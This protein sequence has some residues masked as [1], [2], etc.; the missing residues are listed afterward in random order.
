MSQ[1]NDQD[2]TLRELG[3]GLKKLLCLRLDGC[4]AED[5]VGGTLLGWYE[6]IASRWADEE[7]DAP[8][9]QE[10]FRVL[11]RTC[12]HW[13]APA[14]LVEAMPPVAGRNN[15]PRPLK[16]TDEESQRRGLQRCN[17][18]LKRLG[19]SIESPETRQ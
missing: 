2:W 9:V 18:I 17:E 15:E 11:M 5:A 4:P 10:G 16:L 13:P 7:T 8:R 19:G 6:A 1:A 3:T 12:K 14:E